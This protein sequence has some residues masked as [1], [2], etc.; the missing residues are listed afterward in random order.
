MKI[1]EVGLTVNQSYIDSFIQNLKTNSDDRKYL[2]EVLIHV[3]KLYLKD[4][5][6]HYKIVSGFE[7]RN[8]PPFYGGVVKIVS[9]G[10]QELVSHHQTLV[11]AISSRIK[12]RK[13]HPVIGSL[14]L[15][16]AYGMTTYLK[17]HENC[18][19]KLWHL[20]NIFEWNRSHLSKMADNAKNFSVENFYVYPI[21]QLNWYKFLVQNLKNYIEINDRE[22]DQIKL[23]E[24]EIAK[25][26]KEIILG[27]ENSLNNGRVQALSERAND[28]M[29]K[30]CPNVSD[31]GELIIEG[32]VTVSK[33]QK[34]S[35][36]WIFLFSGLLIP[37]IIRENNNT[38]LTTTSSISST[39]SLNSSVNHSLG[40]GVGVSGNG[41][42]GGNIGA[43]I[44]SNSDP[45]HGVEAVIPLQNAWIGNLPDVQLFTNAFVVFTPIHQWTFITASSDEKKIWMGCITEFIQKSLQ[46]PLNSDIG[47]TPRK[48]KYVFEDS[49]EYDG[50][51]LN[52]KRH[53]IGK[54]TVPTEY[55]YKGEWKNENMRGRGKLVILSTAPNI[56][57]TIFKGVWTDWRGEGTIEVPKK[58]K[59]EGDWMIDIQKRKFVAFGKTKFSSGELYTGFMLQEKRHGYGVTT[60]PDQRKYLGEWQNDQRQGLGFLIEENGVFF[61]GS[62]MSDSI[63]G[64]GLLNSQNVVFHGIFEG[65]WLLGLKINGELDVHPEMGFRN[66]E[67]KLL[68]QEH[69]RQW[70]NFLSYFFQLHLPDSF[71]GLLNWSLIE[72]LLKYC[73][74]L[75]NETFNG[76]SYLS[77]IPRIRFLVNSFLGNLIPHIDNE[78]LDILEKIHNTLL[79]GIFSVHFPLYSLKNQLIDQELERQFSSF[80]TEGVLPNQLAYSKN[81]KT[82]L[83]KPIIPIFECWRDQNLIPFNS[84]NYQKNKP[85]ESPVIPITPIVGRK[86]TVSESYSSITSNYTH[87][88][89]KSQPLSILDS[90][91]FSQTG[92]HTV[93]SGSITIPS[94]TSNSVSSTSSSLMR[95]LRSSLRTSRPI[96]VGRDDL[97]QR[98]ADSIMD[99][100]GNT[101]PFGSSPPPTGTFMGPPGASFDARKSKMDADIFGEKTQKYSEKPLRRKTSEPKVEKSKVLDIEKSKSESNNSFINNNNKNIKSMDDG[102]EKEFDEKENDDEQQQQQQQLLEEGE[103]EIIEFEKREKGIDQVLEEAIHS[104]Q[105]INIQSSCFEKINSLR[106]C[107]NILKYQLTVG[108]NARPI[109]GE[110]LEKTLVYVVCKSGVKDLVAQLHYIKDFLPPHSNEFKRAYELIDLYN[111]AI[112]YLITH[113]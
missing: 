71:N 65:N 61:M 69:S 60:S 101:I 1:S 81:S 9:N 40:N 77:L 18:F 37:T 104:F 109:S 30:L 84:T 91:S 95:T 13:Q 50:E 57:N 106:T 52:A 25:Q 92:A 17:F 3:E 27:I 33:S 10:L 89:T 32:L 70:N 83:F 68:E 22:G 20:Q 39:P 28:V 21:K 4:L 56:P 108:K 82:R 41:P 100:S 24:R 31:G 75:I 87:P 79:S 107:V 42:G 54:Y 44:V 102:I 90:L 55:Y 45:F 36:Y 51:W 78:S 93:A 15:D 67:E 72:R 99:R 85:T 7:T 35:K 34:L 86:S 64:K 12:I 2:L 103:E 8:I 74:L 29:T 11:S 112:E 48:F 96:E 26:M 94:S 59:L 47:L 110:D 113:K 111:S 88:R 23:A 76:K 38:Q 98:S 14:L 80:S 73:I 58:F 62:F 66:R 46:L 16:I 63:E 6:L 53:G 97:T 43:S 19:N 49:S 105:Q 5:E